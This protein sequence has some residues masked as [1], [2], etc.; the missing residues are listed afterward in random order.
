M[1]H[2]LECQ[3]IKCSMRFL[4]N[5]WKKCTIC[6]FFL[7]NS[8]VQIGGFNTFYYVWLVIETF[9]K[10]T[11]NLVIKNINKKRES[12]YYKNNEKKKY[13]K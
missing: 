5:V 6:F 4:E 8:L 2:G 13:I 9:D 3:Q 1:W 11:R 10:S 7:L 12:I